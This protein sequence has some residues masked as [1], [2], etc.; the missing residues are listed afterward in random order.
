M[1]RLNKPEK[2]I[3][4]DKGHN[5]ESEEQEQQ[6]EHKTHNGVF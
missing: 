3:L 1:D 6:Q 2:A 5:E 4:Q